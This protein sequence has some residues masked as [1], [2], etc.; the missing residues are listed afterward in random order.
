M[1]DSNDVGM[2]DA[3]QITI[4]PAC[5]AS[6]FHDGGMDVHG[7]TLN[8]SLLTPSRQYRTWLTT[9]QHGAQSSTAGQGSHRKILTPGKKYLKRIVHPETGRR[10]FVLCTASESTDPEGRAQVTLVKTGELDESQEPTAMSDLSAF[11][12]WDVTTD[13]SDA[14]DAAERAMAVLNAAQ[15]DQQ[16]ANH[17]ESRRTMDDFGLSDAGGHLNLALAGVDTDMSNGNEGTG[18]GDIQAFLGGRENERAPYEWW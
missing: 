14:D 8:E 6:G 1:S 4:E 18:I 2:P 15:D 3:P 7:G 17:P 10:V 12:V 13:A 16:N 5:E 9:P 11:E